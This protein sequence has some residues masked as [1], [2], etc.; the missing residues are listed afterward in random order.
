MKNELHENG[1]LK[2]CKVI[3]KFSFAKD[4]AESVNSESQVFLN[5][6]G[7]HLSIF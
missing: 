1:M 6:W 5:L 7:S 2:E 3:I 4:V